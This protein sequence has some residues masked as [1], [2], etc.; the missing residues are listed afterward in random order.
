M[1]QHLNALYKIQSGNIFFENLLLPQKGEDLY[2][3]RQKVGLVFQHPE[4]QLFSP[5]VKEE[6][7][8]APKNAG[9]KHEK[10]EEAILYSLECVGLDKNFLERNPFALSGG[11]KRLVAI[12]S[13]LAAK[14]EC[15]I[16]DEPLAGL[17]AFYCKKIL[18]MLKNLR[19]NEGKTIIIITHDWKAALKYSDK[20]LI[21]QDGK[22]FKEGTPE[23]I[24]KCISQI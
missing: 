10:L 1:I 18:G 11:E 22:I 14:P 9:F 5:T 17:D 12:A 2:I 3:L 24:K 19:D 21:L 6:L 13:V 20:I 7:A 8:F 23:E 4:D 16:L 15:V